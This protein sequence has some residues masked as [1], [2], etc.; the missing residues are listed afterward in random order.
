MEV[1][2]D[3]A[4]LAQMEMDTSLD[5]R[6]PQGVASKY[7]RIMQHIR[8]AARKNQLYQIGSLRLKKMQAR[9][10]EERIWINDKYRLE[11]AFEG[12]PP[13]ERVRILRISNHYGD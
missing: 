9:D 13:D 4:D 11:L 3:D 10:G 5:S 7:R 12:T 8:I 1:D 6:Y 2:H